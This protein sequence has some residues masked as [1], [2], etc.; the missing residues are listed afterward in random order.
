MKTFIIKI[1]L[2]G[3]HRKFM[4][5]ILVDFLRN[6]YMFCFLTTTILD[7]FAKNIYKNFV[8]KILSV[9][10]VILLNS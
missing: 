10:F 3:M 6:K 1:Y 7:R 8:F 5:F 9:I 2:F 4:H